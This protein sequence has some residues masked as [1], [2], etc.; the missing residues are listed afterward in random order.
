VCELNLGGS[1]GLLRILSADAEGLVKMEEMIEKH[2]AN[3]ALWLDEFIA[4][5]KTKKATA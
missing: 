5:S 2:G 1:D 4:D 3:P